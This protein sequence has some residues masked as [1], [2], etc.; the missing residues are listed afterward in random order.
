[1]NAKKNVHEDK[2]GLLLVLQIAH[3]LIIYIHKN[4]VSRKLPLKI[5]CK[6]TVTGKQMISISYLLAYIGSF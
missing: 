2:Q 4:L 3:I 6:E 1:M 5:V